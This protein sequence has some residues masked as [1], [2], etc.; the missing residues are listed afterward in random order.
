MVL[1]NWPTAKL[2]VLMELGGAQRGIGA[3]E[4]K[5]TSDGWLYREPVNVNE[6]PIRIKYD[7]SFILTSNEDFAEGQLELDNVVRF[8]GGTTWVKLCMGSWFTGVGQHV[9]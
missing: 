7:G 5:S 9:R 6:N 4:A 1:R 3:N 8:I 2:A